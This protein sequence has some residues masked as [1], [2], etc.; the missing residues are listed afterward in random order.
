VGRRNGSRS[1]LS[2]GQ[3]PLEIRQKAALL[4]GRSGGFLLAG[5]VFCLMFPIT[6][7]KYE[8]IKE[9]MAK[10]ASGQPYSEDAFADLL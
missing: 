8:A 3:Q 4:A 7:K 2:V 6:K 10:K 9:A 1:G 5:T